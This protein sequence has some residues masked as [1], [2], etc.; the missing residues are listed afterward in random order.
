[1]VEGLNTGTVAVK[2]SFNVGVYSDGSGPMAVVSYDANCRTLSDHIWIE[3]SSDQWV[4]I[5]YEHASDLCAA[6]KAAASAIASTQAK[7]EAND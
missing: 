4:A 6:I 3:T 1:M 5:P 2:A 7:D